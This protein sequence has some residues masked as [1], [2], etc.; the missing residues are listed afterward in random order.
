MILNRRIKGSATL[1]DLLRRPKFH[2]QHLEQYG[3]GNNESKNSRK[4]RG[5]N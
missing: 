1:A 3:L 4:R 5:R 2:Y